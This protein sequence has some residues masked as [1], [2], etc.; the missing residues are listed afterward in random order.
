[1]K[2]YDYNGLLGCVSQH[3]SQKTKVIVGVYHGEQSGLDCDTE[4]PWLTVCETHGA[5]VGHPTL[6]LAKQWAPYSFDWCEDCM[7]GINHG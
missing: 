6:K 5:C 4:T 3:K 2:T 1:M 7:K